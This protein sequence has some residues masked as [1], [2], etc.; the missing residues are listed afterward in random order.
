VQKRKLE[1]VRRLHNFNLH[2]DLRYEITKEAM[3]VALD[4][5]KVFEG[6]KY[7]SGG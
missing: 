7:K 1:N 4:D 2:L 6:K 3:G 5:L